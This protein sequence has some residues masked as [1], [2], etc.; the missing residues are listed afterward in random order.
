MDSYLGMSTYFGNDRDVSLASASLSPL[1]FV[2]VQTS[3]KQ[4]NP[5]LNEMKRDIT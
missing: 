2:S 4:D 3:Y 1:C 5:S